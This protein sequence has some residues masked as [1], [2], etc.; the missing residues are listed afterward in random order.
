MIDLITHIKSQFES[1][2][3]QRWTR[4]SVPGGEWPWLNIRWSGDGIRWAHLEEYTMTPKVHIL[5]L[6]IMPEL[7]RPVPIYGFDLIGLS[8]QLTGL[9]IDFTETAGTPPPATDYQFREPRPRPPWTGFF[10]DHFVCV[11]PHDDELEHATQTL[12]TWL[13]IFDNTS[14]DSS[15]TEMVRKNQHSYCVNQQQNDKTR[16]ML[17]AHI[18]QELA[19][20]FVEQVLFPAEELVE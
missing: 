17:K 20:Q 6:V 10:S 13:D 18:G 9:F 7:D 15:V 4:T 11:R 3:D 5:H 12:N 19:D 1:V 2:L 8:D 16:K 14:A